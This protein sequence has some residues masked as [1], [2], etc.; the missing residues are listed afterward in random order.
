MEMLKGVLEEELVNSKRRVSA[1]MEALKE[2]LKGS[3]HEKEIKGKKYFYR[4][5]WNPKSK[6][7]VFE[8]LS[9]KPSEKL[10]A[11]YEKAKAK[12]ASY[13]NQI[14]ILKLQ[15]HFLERVL[16]AREF[17]IAEECSKKAA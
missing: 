3:L 10:I 8:L 12:R 13:K 15:V 14:R 17:R 4:V 7:N 5:Y 6:K 1:F 16:R 11:S 9:D 2:L